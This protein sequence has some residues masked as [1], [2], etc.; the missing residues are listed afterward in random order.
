MVGA[1]RLLIAADMSYNRETSGQLGYWGPGPG[2]GPG[3]DRRDGH[4]RCQTSARGTGSTAWHTLKKS[5]YPSFNLGR[6]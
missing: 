1:S 5:E 2:P 6:S 3:Y 4:H